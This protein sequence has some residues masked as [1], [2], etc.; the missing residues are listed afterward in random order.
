MLIR[1]YIYICE[2]VC[3]YL[4]QACPWQLSVAHGYNHLCAKCPDAYLHVLSYIYIYIYNFYL[5]T[6][7]YYILYL[8]NRF[9][10]IFITLIF[11][12]HN[13]YILPF[14]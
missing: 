12:S 2:Y 6:F 9:S 8:V 14:H 13:E 7:Y 11:I 4:V 5:T 10:I 3:I 1:V